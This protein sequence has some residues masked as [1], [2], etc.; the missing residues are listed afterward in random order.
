MFYIIATVLLAIR[1][2]NK[3]IPKNLRPSILS[4]NALKGFN[5]NRLFLNKTLK[6]LLKFIVVVLQNHRLVR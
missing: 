3:K 1:K 6:C 2:Y 5:I 4:F